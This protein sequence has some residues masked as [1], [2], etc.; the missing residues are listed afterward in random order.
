MS[1]SFPLLYLPKGIGWNFVKSPRFATTTQM[2]QS[3]SH[4]AIYTMQTSVVYDFELV[5]NYL[6]NVGVSFDDDAEYLMAFYEACLGGYGYFRFDPAVNNFLNTTVSDDP[7]TLKN[8]FSGLGDGATTVFPLWRSTYALGNG[9]YTGVERIQFVN[10]LTGIY[11][12]GVLISPTAYVLSQYPAT[13][14]FTT[15][16]A[17]GLPVCW[18]GAYQFL[19]KFAEDTLD[20]NNFSYQLWEAKSIKL[21]SILL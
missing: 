1:L 21:E 16:P 2:P 11:V 17:L 6:K 5:F 14:T 15:P 20:F 12:N 9:S 10:N 8:G 4:P 18:A 13:V 3:Q 7:T 19:C